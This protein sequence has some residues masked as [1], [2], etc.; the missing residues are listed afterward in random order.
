MANKWAGWQHNRC[1]LG[2]PTALVRGADSE[3]AHKWDRCLQNPCRL[4]CPHRF[5]AKVRIRIGQQV[6]WV[7]A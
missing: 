2:V 5:S 3:V 7:A 6:G 4:E 1:R